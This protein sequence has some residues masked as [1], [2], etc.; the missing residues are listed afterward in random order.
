M[1]LPGAT[2][3][4]LVVALAACGAALGGE[5]A[6][7]PT[8]SMRIDELV[9]AFSDDQSQ[10]DMML[11]GSP[12]ISDT[13][14]MADSVRL[15][16]ESEHAQHWVGADADGD[17]CLITKLAG[18]SEVGAVSCTPPDSFHRHGLSLEVQAGRGEGVVSHLLPADIDASV[19]AQELRAQT[20]DA[21]SV[22]VL[23]ETASRLI[24]MDPIA[25]GSAG[26]V[27]VHRPGGDFR[28]RP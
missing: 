14:V 25:A 26:E 27:M 12:L 9:P 19:V 23:S 24:V 16:G 1:R 8:P 4:L 28:L 5:D 15:L 18:T 6:R 13:D 22:R 3:G 11:R 20:K 2:A 21:G 10:A 7:E 17:V